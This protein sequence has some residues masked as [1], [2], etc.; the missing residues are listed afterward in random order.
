MESLLTS[1]RVTVA[2]LSGGSGK[3]IIAMALLLAARRT[4]LSARAFKKGPDYIDA[5]WLSWAA[6]HPARNLDTY[7]MGFEGAT[8]SFV[9]HAI[10]DGLNVVEGNRGVFDGMD[11]AGTHSTAALAEALSS[12]LVLVLNVTKV[13]RSVAAY[14]LGAQKLD[15]QLN[16]AGIVLNYVNGRRH[17]QIVRDSIAAV[18]DVPVVGAVPRLDLADLVPERHLGLVTPDEHSA[19]AMLERKL[20]DDVVAHLD[21]ETILRIARS[22]AALQAAQAPQVPRPGGSRV[23]IGYIKDAAF[24]F[25]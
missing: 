6:G 25:Y 4:G 7:L 14:V 18:C 11:A 9:R 20:L 24:S 5:A 3:T 13:T 17:E 15:P 1:P 22:A 19:R 12:P 10:H 16:I 23:K 21:F 8:G 2:G